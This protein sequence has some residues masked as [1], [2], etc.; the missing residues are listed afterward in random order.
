MQ[1]QARLASDFCT[2]L[3]CHR[4]QGSPV[5]DGS[6]VR[7]AVAGASV[8]GVN[9]ER[10]RVPELERATSTACTKMN[11]AQE[12]KWGILAHFK[13]EALCFFLMSRDNNVRCFGIECSALRRL[14]STSGRCGDPPLSHG[15]ARQSGPAAVP[16]RPP[17]SRCRSQQQ[18]ERIAAMQCTVRDLEAE[19]A[20]H[21]RRCEVLQRQIASVEAEASERK[22]CVTACEGACG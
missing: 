11:V 9:T 5:R 16:S 15:A 22:V 20:S 2:A 3:H 13:E 4:D 6:W 18:L 12:N 1:G 19:C 10:V 17:S 8:W 14:Q 7:H 21:K